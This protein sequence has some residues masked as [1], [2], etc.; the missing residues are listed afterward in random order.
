VRTLCELALRKH[1]ER[2]AQS[3]A[4]N[5]DSNDNKTASPEGPTLARLREEIRG[6][7]SGS[8]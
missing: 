5:D 7:L 4:R 6:L 2:L 3:D 8:T 1:G